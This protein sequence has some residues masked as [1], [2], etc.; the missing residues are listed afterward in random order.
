MKKII[1]GK[2]I[3][4]EENMNAEGIVI[5]DGINIIFNYWNVCIIA[6]KY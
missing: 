5:N 2:V 1:L 4:L 6:I 3:T